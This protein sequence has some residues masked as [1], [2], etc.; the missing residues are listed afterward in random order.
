MSDDEVNRLFEDAASEDSPFTPMLEALRATSGE[1]VQESES[2]QN[3]HLTH[4]QFKDKML[5]Q[6]DGWPLLDLLESGEWRICER[7]G[8]CNGYIKDGVA[9][10]DVPRW[11]NLVAH[12]R[13]VNS[14]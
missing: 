9:Y 10:I 13:I 5:E 2:T 14:I 1:N 7:M 3:L 12:L 6:A 8:L 4:Q 11:N